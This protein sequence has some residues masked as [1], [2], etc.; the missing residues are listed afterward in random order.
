MDRGDAS[1]LLQVI[2][3]AMTEIYNRNASQLSFEELYRNAYNLVLHKH[4]G[5]LYDGVV[6]KMTRHLRT[7]VDRLLG[8]TGGGGKGGYEDGESAL[9]FATSASEAMEDGIG[10]SNQASS[11]SSSPALVTSVAEAWKEHVLTLVMIRDILMY[12][13]RTYVLQAK[14]RSVYDLGLHLW[15]ITVWD[16]PS[17]RSNVT[18]L[19]LLQILHERQGRLVEDRT[20]LKTI[21]QMLLE[22]G[23]ADYT[24]NV[25]VDFEAQFLAETSEFYHGESLRY[26]SEGSALAYV[27]RATNRIGEEK[28]RAAALLLPASTEAPLMN[29]VQ[30]ELIERHAKTLVDMEKTGFSAMLAADGV[31]GGG[32]GSANYAAAGGSLGVGGGMSVPDADN[33]KLADMAAMYRLFARVPSSVDHLRDALADRIKADGRALVADQEQRNSGGATGAADPSAFVRGVLAMRHKYETVVATGFC[34][35]KKAQK[36]MR[37]AFEDFLNT[38]AR[39]ASCLAVYVDELLRVGL[40]GATEDVVQAELGRAIV[41]F[42]YLSDKDVF[43]S[44]YKQHLAKRLLASRS[45]S[46]EAEKLMVSLLKAECGYQFTTKLEGMFNDMRISRETRDKWKQYSGSTASAAAATT[47]NRI[48]GAATSSTIEATIG[49]DI[50]V[51]VLT[52]GYWPSQNVPPCTLPPQVQFAI[53]QFSTFYLEKH[54]GRKLSWQTSAGAAELKAAFGDGSPGQP[55]R[56]HELCVSTYQMCILLLFNDNDTLTLGQIR[57][58]TH[59]PDLELRRQ[60]ISLCT[61]RNRIL[62]KGSKGKGITSDDDTFTYNVDYTSKLKRV[63]IPLVKETSLGGPAKPGD[64]SAAG[65]AAGAGMLTDGAGGSGAAATTLVDGSV[66]VAVE[67]DRRHLVEAAIV[68]IMK[69]R[70]SLNHN[71]LIAEVTKQLS[72]RF[73]P[74]PNFIKK[75]IE[76]LIEREYLERSENE[77]RV[78]LYVA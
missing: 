49:F 47:T 45:V 78:Y 68:R 52:T 29:I 16:H 46:D 23:S 20:S 18:E 7:V 51:D 50:E 37:E 61:P 2:E 55:Y 32:V 21:L 28:E 19:V 71:D 36:R 25:Y 75:R 60:L 73:T 62:K 38:D 17:I 77:H 56:R 33:G 39:A 22:L 43:E 26:L 58:M 66:P 8:N 59:I 14:R 24:A 48:P 74:T 72:I 3:R 4:G 57:T 40:R 64:P 67:E 11:S 65:A 12:M 63:R 13:D 1:E 5:L 27:H 70:K 9:S 34:G 76:S 10:A 44:F 53:D 31:G 30:T 35:E 6:D 15:K 41:I 42:R 69:A 54:T